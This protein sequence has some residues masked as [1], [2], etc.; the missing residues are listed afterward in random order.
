MSTVFLLL[1]AQFKDH[2]SCILCPNIAEPALWPPVPR[3][4]QGNL[5]RPSVGK[6]LAEPSIRPNDVLASTQ[7]MRGTKGNG[8]LLS[9]DP[10][11]SRHHRSTARAGCTICCASSD[12]P[13]W[14]DR[15][16]SGVNLS[17]LLKIKTSEARVN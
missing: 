7:G 10:R 9:D 13:S 11:S 2:H 15:W 1:H 6:G 8:L 4:C 17:Y 16:N 14:P 5:M 3:P 12:I